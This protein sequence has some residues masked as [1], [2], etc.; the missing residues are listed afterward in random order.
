MD[1]LNV[2]DNGEGGSLVELCFNRVLDC[3]CCLILP[4][5]YILSDI[6]GW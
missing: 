2:E 1:C 5:V 4:E 3:G 6:A